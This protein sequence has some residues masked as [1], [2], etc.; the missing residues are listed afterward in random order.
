MGN[1]VAVME[2]PPMGRINVARVV[3]GG[4]VAG[5]VINVSEF[6][7]N[8]AVLVSDMNAALAR[9]NLPPIGGSA[10][11]MFIVL[12]FVGG[13]ATVWLYAAMRPRFGPGPSTGVITGLVVWF[14]VYFYGGVALYAMG[15]FPARTMAISLGW[16]LGESII[17]AL[18]GS[19]LYAEG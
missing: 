19:A 4:I 5:L 9:M 17:A 13:L 12:G 1:A 15:M 6:V 18:A 2:V 10:I 11:P 14:F 7:L 8:Q 16:G 3:I